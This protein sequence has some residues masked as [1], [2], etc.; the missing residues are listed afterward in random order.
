MNEVRNYWVLNVNDFGLPNL[1]I[2]LILVHLHQWHDTAPEKIWKLQ[3]LES[4]RPFDY[5]VQSYAALKQMIKS[6][7]ALHQV[8]TWLIHTNKSAQNA[9]KVKMPEPPWL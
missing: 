3:K 7:A 9:I 1:Y 8:C 4:S 2:C 6:Y 5:K